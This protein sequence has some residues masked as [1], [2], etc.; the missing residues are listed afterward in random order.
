MAHPFSLGP[1]QCG[2]S[3]CAMCILKWFFSRLHRACGGWHEPVDCPICRTHLILTPDRPP[4]PNFTFPLVPNRIAS[5]ILESLVQKL[6][7]P[8]IAPVIKKEDT[9]S[10][11]VSS[12]G[13]TCTADC[14]SE[15]PKPKEEATDIMLWRE[16]G[17]M[18]AEWL[19]KDRFVWRHRS[20]TLAYRSPIET[21][22]EKWVICC[23]DGNTLKLM[24]SSS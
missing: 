5:S 12:P 21:A 7:R 8:P 11:W 20:L 23:K 17:C 9:D 3:F 18:R 16:G 15:S 1:A 19:K 14:L 13:Q 6:A 4:R 2:H 22:G 24:N 10:S